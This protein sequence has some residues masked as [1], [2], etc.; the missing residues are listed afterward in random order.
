MEEKMHLT[1]VDDDQRVLDTYK[2]LFKDSYDLEIIDNPL[3]LK[4]FIKNN[5]TDLILMD[6][7]MPQINGVDLF[8]LIRN[9]LGKT[10]V[11]FIS[12][13]AKDEAIIR[14]MDLGADDFISRP[15]SNSVLKSRI[16]NKIEKAGKFIS[17]QDRNIRNIF[18]LNDE[19]EAII[20]KDI[21]YRLTN[22]EFKIIS[23]LAK[24]LGKIHTVEEIYQAIWPGMKVSKHALA[25]HINNL[26]NK[27]PPLA[28]M[29]INKRC[30]GYYLDLD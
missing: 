8:E 18:I 21:K 13:N 16:Q 3:N 1:I 4:P 11:I 2:D 15:I 19:F 22:H 27:V 17:S 10:P 7:N 30:I 23:F 24:D 14:G 29:I 26:K 25:T 12:S 9:D 6:L 5:R 28:P 20:I